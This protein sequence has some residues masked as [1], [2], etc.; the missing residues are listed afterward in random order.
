MHIE[1]NDAD[2]LFWEEPLKHVLIKEK[3]NGREYYTVYTIE[4]VLM[5]LLCDD[6]EYCLQLSRKMIE[7]GV[8]VFDSFDEFSKWYK[9][10]GCNAT[11]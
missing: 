4:P 6:F 8:R 7:S 10:N 2:K 1:L 11:I 9:C 5:T 3:E